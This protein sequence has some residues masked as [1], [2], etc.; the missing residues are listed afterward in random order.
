ML[1]GL[2]PAPS[3]HRLPIDSTFAFLPKDQRDE[4]L[5]RLSDQNKLEEMDTYEDGDAE[6]VEEELAH[7]AK[8]SQQLIAKG[9]MLKSSDVQSDS[10][11]KVITISLLFQ[12][13]LMFVIKF[14]MIIRPLSR[15]RRFRLA[16]NRLLLRQPLL[17]VSRH[18]M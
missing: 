2:Q 1:G 14:S 16:R 18:K 10:S 6:V 15:R 4:V 11:F 8:K 13:S 12:S 7:E 9:H 3:H 5:R 17:Q